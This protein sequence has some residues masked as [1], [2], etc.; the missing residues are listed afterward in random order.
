M[1]ATRKERE[2]VASLLHLLST[3]LSRLAHSVVAV[4]TVFLALSNGMRPD[5]GHKLA[6]FAAIGP[7]VYAG[8]VLHTFPFSLMRKFTNR[9]MW[10]FVFGSKDYVCF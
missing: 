3:P 7:S 9:L 2:P 8:P 4:D 6:G 1:S 5:L 10:Q